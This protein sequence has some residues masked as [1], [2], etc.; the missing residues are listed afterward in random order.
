VAP[1][2]EALTNPLVTLD[3]YRAYDFIRDETVLVRYITGG[4][5]DLRRGQLHTTRINGTLRP[6]ANADLQVNAEYTR[7]V[8]RGVASPLPP[9]SLDVQAAFP[10]RYRRDAEGRLFEIDARL[11]SFARSQ[12]E[13]LR[14]GGSFRRSFGVPKVAPRPGT[15]Q[16]VISD[17]TSDLSGAGW[18]LRSNLTHTWLLSSTRLV[19]E[20]L[21]VVNLLSGGT[22]GYNATPRHIVRSTVGL[23]HNGTGL[24]LNATWRS[25]SRITGG[26]PA[27]PNDIEFHP[28][29]GAD[30][31][32]FTELGQVF[33]RY[34]F[35]KGLRVSLNVEN[36]F[37]SRQRVRDQSGN[38]PL[39]YQPYLL[40]PTGRTVALS[41]RKN[42]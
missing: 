35:T 20:G 38:T 19:R 21:P 5:P 30:V 29:L 15:P 31:S 2:P 37:D 4:N 32:A 27:A 39:R 7:T 22:A 25:A 18:R 14:W 10:D 36:L 6:F 11:V 13:Q 42:F 41:L 17:D 16:F 26:T 3:G 23:A 8:S 24:D 12:T 40:N 1:Q 33:P 34:P 28:F 9:V